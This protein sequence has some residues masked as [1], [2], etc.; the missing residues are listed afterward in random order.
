MTAS[1]DSRDYQPGIGTGPTDSGKSHSRPPCPTCG[2]LDIYV[3]IR[4][5]AWREEDRVARGF[6][7]IGCRGCHSAYTWPV[8]SAEALSDAYRG[9]YFEVSDSPSSVRFF[10]L[11]RGF[12]RFVNSLTSYPTF[13]VRNQPCHSVLEIGAGR[14]DVLRSIP[15]EGLRKVAIEPN[16]VASILGDN[17]GV[18]FIRGTAEDVLPLL[19]SRFD[20]II[21]HHSLE[22]V[23][24][25]RFVLTHCNRLLSKGGL[26][27]VAVPSLDSL[28]FRLFG[29]KWD[30]LD[31]PRHLNHWS[32]RGLTLLLRESGFDPVSLYFQLNPF[33]F[34]RTTARAFG[35][36]RVLPS[37]SGQYPGSNTV[38]ATSWF[39]ILVWANLIGLESVAPYML[40]DAK[41]HATDLSP[42][43]RDHAMV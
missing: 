36:S 35:G 27:T 26:L 22:H 24:E 8:P 23:R 20:W 10:D 33:P 31:I 40:I 3:L 13:R 16:P 18:E 19:D 7:I 2:S 25:P 6:S 30:P 15:G 34:A 39:M 41:P 37:E 14:G 29:A 38:F 1:V 43:G 4:D 12:L 32:S 17:A 42:P 5:D 21:L 28:G 9:V 11:A